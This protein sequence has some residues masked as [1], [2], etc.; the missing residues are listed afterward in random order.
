MPHGVLDQQSFLLGVWGAPPERLSSKYMKLIYCPHCLD[1]KKL[2]RLELRR[3][4]CGRSWGYYQEDDL[5]AVIGGSAVP[6]AIENDELRDAIA[7]RPKEG[8]GSFLAARVLPEKYDTLRR[9]SEPEPG[10]AEVD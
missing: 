7:D 8:R 5:T 10:V 3:C 4:A 6:V 9:Q 2:R 1:M